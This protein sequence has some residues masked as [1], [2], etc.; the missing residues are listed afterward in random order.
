[1]EH[2]GRD[3]CGCE[4]APGEDV[5]VDERRFEVPAQELPAG[6][7]EVVARV[8]TDVAAPYDP[9]PPVP[10]GGGEAGRLRVVEHDEV[11]RSHHRREVGGIGPQHRL[12]VLVLGLT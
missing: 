8:D 2:G 4:G 10:H 12:V 9:G 3:P 7:R 6:H 11:A 1:V 5:G